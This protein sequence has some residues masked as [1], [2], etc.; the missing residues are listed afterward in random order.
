MALDLSFTSLAD[1]AQSGGGG[2]PVEIPLDDIIEDP[3]QPRT[4]FDD[5]ALH[6]LAASI[7]RFGVIQAIS[8][9]PK[10]AAG[11]H[12][13]I[14]GARRYRA[15]RLAGRDRIRAVVEAAETPDA[16]LQLV[17][18]IQR[19]DL[20]PLEIAA[21]V[22]GR[23]KAGDRTSAIAERLGKPKDWVSRY[24]AVAKMPD[25]LR[26]KL[27]TSPIRAVYELFQAW[28]EHPAAVEDIARSQGVFTD[29]QARR[30]AQ[31][32][33]KP[34]PVPH[35]PPPSTR[36]R[37]ID[38]N[39]DRQA[40][41]EGRATPE[42]T[43]RHRPS[44]VADEGSVEDRRRTSASPLRREVQRLERRMRAIDTPDAAQWLA[45]YDTLSAQ[46]ADELSDAHDVWVSRRAALLLIRSVT[47]AE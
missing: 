24:A 28:R 46:L 19:D 30:I 15:S 18:N 2:R 11:K 13:I 27:A 38:A 43:D 26:D 36:A 16:Y 35:P 6:E 23:L 4:V 10:N 45:H 33:R 40:S 25:V 3:D 8:V 37:D 34:E 9:R 7:A 21:F 17:E 31:D 47:E 42:I 39:C 44:I 5:D 22:T 32:L 12:I 41:G 20:K 1:I 29:A 14:F